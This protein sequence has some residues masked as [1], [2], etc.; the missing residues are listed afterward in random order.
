MQNLSVP[1]ITQDT[2]NCNVTLCAS[3]SNPFSPIHPFLPSR[4]FRASAKN[5]ACFLLPPPPSYK[6]KISISPTPTDGRTDGRKSSRACA[7]LITRASIGFPAAAILRSLGPSRIPAAFFFPFPSERE[8]RPRVRTR[9]PDVWRDPS[10]RSGSIP[11]R[12]RPH[13]V[14]A[15]LLD[16]DDALIH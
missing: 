9:T 4:S 10:T 8:Q 15:A 11:D 3:R 16:H 1:I 13:L 12:T 5:P 6:F 2:T 7:C 14:L